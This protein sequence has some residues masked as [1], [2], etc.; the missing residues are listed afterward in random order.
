[1]ATTD[2]VERRVEESDSSRTVKRAAAAKQILV[3]AQRQADAAE[4]LAT[5]ERELGEAIADA[6]AV[7]TI[8]ELATFTDI[9]AADLTT[10][11]DHRKPSRT[12]RKRLTGSATAAKA[13][14]PA[15]PGAAS[16][17]PTGHA[18]SPTRE[19]TTPHEQ[20]N[21]TATPT[22]AGARR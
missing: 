2:D 14:P 9:P 17:T 16:E 8:V 18:E 21:T 20:A 22:V 3:L 11:R 5:V 19:Q 13:T 12:K 15:T 6:A 10:W 7:I 4:E 1:M